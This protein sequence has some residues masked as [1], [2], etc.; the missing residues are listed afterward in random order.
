[1]R[2]ERGGTPACAPAKRSAPNES[3]DEVGLSQRTAAAL[4]SR[5]TG[6]TSAGAVPENHRSSSGTVGRCI[7]PV[8]LAGDTQL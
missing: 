8:M 6:G 4:Q 2:K 5:T 1:M 7:E 3:V